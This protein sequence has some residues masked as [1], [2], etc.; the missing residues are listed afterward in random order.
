MFCVRIGMQV[1][2]IHSVKNIVIGWHSER[3]CTGVGFCCG[4]T[5]ELLFSI[6]YWKYGLPAIL[7]VQLLVIIELTKLWYTVSPEWS[8]G[9]PHVCVAGLSVFF[10]SFGTKLFRAPCSSLEIPE[11]SEIKEFAFCPTEL[12][13]KRCKSLFCPSA[14]SDKSPGFGIMKLSKL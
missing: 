14:N 13:C 7:R 3:D 12:S 5:T 6:F 11:T 8:W 10:L 4:G 1:V 9:L 2:G